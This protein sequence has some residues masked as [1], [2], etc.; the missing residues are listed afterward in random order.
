[1]NGGDVVT[2]AAVLVGG[3]AVLAAYA[4]LRS[5]GRRWR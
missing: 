3:M 2:G 5:Y 1:M 4:W